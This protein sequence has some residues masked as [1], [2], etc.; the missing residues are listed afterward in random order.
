MQIFS[1][2]KDFVINLWLNGND[3]PCDVDNKFS[4]E[5]PNWFNGDLFKRG[6]KYFRDNRAGILLSNLHG[7]LVL[8]ADPKGATM[9]D[10]TGKSSNPETAT[11]RYSSTI[12][13]LISWYECE[14]KP[15]SQ[16]WESLVRVRKMHLSAS[17]SGKTK[18]IGMI[19]QAELTGTQFG[20][21]GYALTRPHL[22]GIRY[23]NKSNQEGFVH[24]WAVIGYMLGIE[25]QFNMC[26]FPL[27]VVEKGQKYFRDNRAGILLSNLHGLLVLIS[28]PKGATLLDHTGKSS[29]PETARKRYSSTLMHMVSWYECEL[30]PG[31]QS[32]ESLVRVRKMHLSA[33]TSGKTKGIGMISQAEL[34]GTQFGFMGYALTR[35]HLLGIRYNNKS[36]QEGFVH[37]WAVIGYMLGIEDQFNMCLFPLEVVE[38]ICQ[39]YI[40]YVF[41]PILQLELPV[42]KKLT[43]SFLS[44]FDMFFPNQ[45]YKST[46]FNLKRVTGV[47]GY[48]YKVDLSKEF[49]CDQIF[50]SEELEKFSM[51]MDSIPGGKYKTKLFFQPKLQLLSQVEESDSIDEVLQSIKV[52]EIND[53]EIVNY[54]NDHQFYKLSADDQKKV[55]LELAKVKV[56]DKLTGR[57]LSD[58]FIKSKIESIRYYMKYAVEC[59]AP[60][61]VRVLK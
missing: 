22:L 44:G 14:L 61:R 9:L 49:F 38:K 34:T 43:K 52:Q 21:M 47:P 31:S 45:S 60:S 18:G 39:I 32:W 35:P 26:L 42:F 46:M 16:S 7:L 5:L 27:E 1:A 6:Q 51:S 10:H 13:H 29:N 36:N 57:L 40:R 28:D 12:L 8:M 15:G 25:D 20:F 48:Q 53:E 59:A 17:T 2:A 3:K 55:N 4:S 50:S 41:V 33:S 37:F 56:L 11:K 54:L 23:N 30:K 19:S 58:M 24:F